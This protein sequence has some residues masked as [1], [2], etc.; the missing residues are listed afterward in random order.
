MP[1]AIT[2]VTWLTTFMLLLCVFP[3]P[4]PQPTPPPWQMFFDAVVWSM[5][6]VI[7]LGVANVINDRVL[8]FRVLNRNSLFEANMATALVEAGGYI[9]SGNCKKN[10]LTNNNHRN[11]TTLAELLTHS[12]PHTLHIHQPSSFAPL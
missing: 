7:Y 12:R 9:G 8:L 1:Q 11:K 5:L 2:F 10:T 3:T 4:C 6:G